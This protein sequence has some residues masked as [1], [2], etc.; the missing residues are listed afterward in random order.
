MYKR[1]EY[2][3]TCILMCTSVPTLKTALSSCVVSLRIASQTFWRLKKIQ[4]S[5]RIKRACRIYCGVSDCF[6]KYRENFANSQ[7]IEYPVLLNWKKR[8][9]ADTISLDKP[10]SN[11]TYAYRLSHATGSFFRDVLVMLFLH[12]ERREKEKQR[13]ARLML[14]TELCLSTLR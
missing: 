9:N 10:R 11:V 5:N 2:T 12:R 3:C 14:E 6:K 7:R 8:Y 4:K 13:A 1:I